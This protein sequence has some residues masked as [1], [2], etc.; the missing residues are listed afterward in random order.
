MVD[1]GSIF[2]ACIKDLGEI[3]TRYHTPSEAPSALALGNVCNFPR[4]QDQATD[5][6]S[7]TDNVVKCVI[8]G[9]REEEREGR[10]RYIFDF[11]LG[12]VYLHSSYHEENNGEPYAACWY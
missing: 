9:S 8:L 11:I 10:G 2:H 3:P 1:M 5:A 4:V 7:R 6:V 12:V